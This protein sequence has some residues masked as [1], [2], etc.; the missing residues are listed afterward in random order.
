VTSCGLGTVPGDR[1]ERKVKDHEKNDEREH[2]EHDAA[3][4]IPPGR[5]AVRPL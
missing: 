1:A 2:P 3:G 4:S 5:L